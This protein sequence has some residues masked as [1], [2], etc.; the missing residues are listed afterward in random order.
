MKEIVARC[1]L[2]LLVC[3]KNDARRKYFKLN[4]DFNELRTDLSNV[5]STADLETLLNFIEIARENM[6]VASKSRLINEFRLLNEKKSKSIKNVV[7]TN[8]VNS[9]NGYCNYVRVFGV[10][11]GVQR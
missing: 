7:N 10:E 2:D 3:A 8:H 11:T 1:E 6:F 5:L 4:N 9:V